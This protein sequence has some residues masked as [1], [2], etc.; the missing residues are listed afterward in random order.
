MS[1]HRGLLLAYG[2][3]LQLYPPTFRRRFGAE[4]LEIAEGAA[5]DEWPLI[6]RDTSV[7]ILRCWLVGS[8]STAGRVDP[9]AYLALGKSLPNASPLLHGLAI[10]IAILVGVIYAGY[11][12][13][14]PCQGSRQVLTR[15]AEPI[16]ASTPDP[17]QDV[18]A[19]KAMESK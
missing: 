4:M 1:V 13:P 17:G 2:F 6:F 8:P 11:R 10:S 12:W 14:P 5:P 7:G 19:H 3:L 16:P 9:D 18:R 15:I